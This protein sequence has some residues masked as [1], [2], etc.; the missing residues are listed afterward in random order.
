VIVDAVVADDRQPEDVATLLLRYG[1][2]IL[3]SVFQRD[4]RTPG[5]GGG[6]AIEV[7]RTDRLGR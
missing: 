2:R 3:L 6:A 4:L 1:A 5:R 7:P